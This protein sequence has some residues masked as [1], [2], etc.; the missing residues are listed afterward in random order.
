MTRGMEAINRL[1]LREA[2]G[3]RWSS[4]M[5]VGDIE[6]KTANIGLDITVVIEFKTANIGLDITVVRRSNIN[7]KIQVPIQSNFLCS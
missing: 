1:C 5:Y 6:L 4:Y 7:L 2:S 3:L